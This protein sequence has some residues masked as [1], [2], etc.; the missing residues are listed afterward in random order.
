[1]EYYYNAHSLG[2][3]LIEV[4]AANDAEVILLKNV[5]NVDGLVK[6]NG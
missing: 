3:A 6:L 4:A 5:M 1:M 2:T